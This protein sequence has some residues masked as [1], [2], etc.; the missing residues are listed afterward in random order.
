M[1][2]DNRE[3]AETHVAAKQR[4]EETAQ[5]SVREEVGITERAL[6]ARHDLE[7]RAANLEERIG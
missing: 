7:T 5:Q 4:I 1:R 2:D 3:P 6:H